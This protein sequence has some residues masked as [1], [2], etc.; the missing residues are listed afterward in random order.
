MLRNMRIKNQI[1]IQT[2]I[3][4]LFILTSFSFSWQFIQMTDTHIGDQVGNDK[5]KEVIPAFNALNPKPDFIFTTGDLT[6][7]GAEDQFSL[8]STYINQIH[9][10]VYS[11]MGNHEIRWSDSNKFRFKRYFGNRC[12]SFDHKGIHFVMLDDT[13]PMQH[14]GHFYQAQL[15]WLKQ[16]LISLK[17]NTPVILAMHHPPAAE[18]RTIDNDVELFD[19]IQ[20]YNVIAILVGHGHVEKSSSYANI[21]I[22]MTKATRT[23]GY[24]LF[25]VGDKEIIAYASEIGKTEA[26][27]TIKISLTRVIPSGPKPVEPN[28]DSKILWKTRIDDG[29]QFPPAAGEGKLFYGTEPGTI[30]AL[31]EKSGK[32]VWKMNIISTIVGSPAYANGMVYIAATDGMIYSLQAK[33][34]VLNWKYQTGGPIIA[35]PQIKDNIVYVGSGDHYFYAIDGLTGQLKWRFVCQNHVS[36]AALVSQGKVY[37]GSWD[38]NAYCL[39]AYTGAIC[40][41]DPIGNSIYWAPSVSAPIQAGNKVIYTALEL[42]DKRV[43]GRVYALDA[44]SGNT[45]WT[46]VTRSCQTNPAYDGKKV[47]NFGLGG[48]IM[49]IDAETGTKSWSIQLKQSILASDIIIKN[50]H[51]YIP[52]LSG[53]LMIVNPIDGKEIQRIPVSKTGFLFSGPVIDND[54][55]YQSAF[56]GTVAAFPI[57]RN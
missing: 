32:P 37:F 42:I 12:Y 5:F 39:D 14:Y 47:Y 23:G 25:D 15:D 50:N 22:L 2:L 18:T 7:L 13:I 3:I 46:M 26:T 41:I 21:P 4:F 55:C 36:A 34:G 33:D 54:I 10:P 29:L 27:D 40:W 9:I 51:F 1:Q 43:L 11:V 31:E 35:S 52:L 56:D 24:K 17:K 57:N 38:G 8:Y 45:A 48:E 44:L 49:A 6:E 16:D 28:L 53:D 19:M 20:P 30:Y